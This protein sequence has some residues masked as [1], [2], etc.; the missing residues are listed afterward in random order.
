MQATKVLLTT[1]N[2]GRLREIPPLPPNARLEAIFLVIEGG[3]QGTAKR[4]PSPRIAGLGAI[5]GDLID[6]VVEADDWEALR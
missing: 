2:D 3:C 4:R 5:H 1:D 6:P